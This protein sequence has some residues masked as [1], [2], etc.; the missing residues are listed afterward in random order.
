M[1]TF[2]FLSVLRNYP[3][4]FSGQAS[5][6]AYSTVTPYQNQVVGLLYQVVKNDSIR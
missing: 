1:S 5:T 2:R 3:L 4:F 6:N